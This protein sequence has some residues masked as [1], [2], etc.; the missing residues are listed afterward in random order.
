MPLRKFLILAAVGPLL[1]VSRIL[2][3]LASFATLS[4][5]VRIDILAWTMIGC[6]W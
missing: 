6:I 1:G 5:P 4:E 2:G 3:L